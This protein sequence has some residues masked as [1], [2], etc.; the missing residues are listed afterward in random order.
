M[1]ARQPAAIGQTK[2]VNNRCRFVPLPQV[3]RVNVDNPADL[4]H[5]Q[6]YPL[7][8][9]QCSAAYRW[10]SPC[11]SWLC[12]WVRSTFCVLSEACRRGDLSWY[13]QA[14]IAN[15]FWMVQRRQLEVNV[16]S[17]WGSAESACTQFALYAHKC[18]RQCPRRQPIAWLPASFS[19]AGCQLA[20]WLCSHSSC[21]VFTWKQLP[22]GAD[23]L[24]GSCLQASA[25][26]ACGPSQRQL[27][28]SA[29]HLQAGLLC[30][31]FTS[32]AVQCTRMLHAGSWTALWSTA[33]SGCQTVA[34]SIYPHWLP[35]CLSWT[36]RPAQELAPQQLITLG[37]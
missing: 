26:R 12:R 6:S 10:W 3:V 22:A 29:L 19:G 34:G 8:I 18:C 9:P 23:Q 17:G 11:S 27:L 2:Q 21:P 7:M 31:H 28:F 4:H 20:C 35:P 37:S 5:D 24:T 33:S 14:A 16:L 1:N 36:F 15:D 30:S 13:L 25:G 32:C